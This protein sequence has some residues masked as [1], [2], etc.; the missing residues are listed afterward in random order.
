[1]RR[2]KYGEEQIIG[3]LKEHEAGGVDGGDLSEVRGEQRDLLQV[4]QQIRRDEGLVCP[5]RARGGGQSFPTL[6]GITGWLRAA[7][8]PRV[9]C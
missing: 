3:I 8:A 2:S 9:A 5:Q 1:M 6:I 4:A 7:A